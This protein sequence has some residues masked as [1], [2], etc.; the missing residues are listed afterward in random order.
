MFVPDDKII[1][2]RVSEQESFDPE[3]TGDRSV[4]CCEVMKSRGS[5]NGETQ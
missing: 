5:S 3:M 1:F 2:H 4:V